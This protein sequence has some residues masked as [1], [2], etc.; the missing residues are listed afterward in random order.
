MI[1]VV[2]NKVSRELMEEAL[3]VVGAF[4][5]LPPSQ[6]GSHSRLP[7]ATAMYIPFWLNREQSDAHSEQISLIVL[8][9]N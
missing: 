9:L 1:A 6:H 7:Q 4:L 2:K 8:V 5:F 3:A